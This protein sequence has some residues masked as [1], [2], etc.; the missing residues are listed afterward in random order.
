MFATCWICFSSLWFRLTQ[1]F[2]LQYCSISSIEKYKHNYFLFGY[3]NY[4][5]MTDSLLGRIPSVKYM[6]QCSKLMWQCLYWFWRSG[7]EECQKMSNN[8]PFIV[9]FASKDTYITLQTF[10][11]FLLFC[12]IWRLVEAC[13]Q[14][15]SS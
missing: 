6:Q 11:C 3:V 5:S 12:M 14:C 10:N 9:S 1:S 2:T 8:S 15:F 7:E 13:E 4:Q